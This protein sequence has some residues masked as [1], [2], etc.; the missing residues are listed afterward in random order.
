MLPLLPKSWERG[1]EL[2]LH[3]WLE[4]EPVQLE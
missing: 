3:N 4:Q 2:V 1:Q